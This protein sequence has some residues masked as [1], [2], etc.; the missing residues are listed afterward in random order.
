MSFLFF[1]KCVEALENGPFSG[2]VQKIMVPGKRC[3]I[4]EISVTAYEAREGDSLQ[5]KAK[6]DGS[7]RAP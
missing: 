1:K 3:V 6:K 7:S 5:K 2:K 4:I